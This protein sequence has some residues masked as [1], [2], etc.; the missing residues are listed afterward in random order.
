MKNLSLL[1]LLVLLFVAACTSKSGVSP[2]APKEIE[3]VLE[4]ATSVEAISVSFSN[5][6]EETT[7]LDKVSLPYSY[8]F[9]NSKEPRSLFIGGHIIDN[10]SATTHQ[11]TAKILV[12]GTIVKQ[13]TGS[14]NNA[15]VNTVF[16]LR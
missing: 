6:T 13:E 4:S 15:L 12:N 1:L 8:K 14:G 10:N 5:E 16:M 7:R 3:Y 9:T 11:I 2:A